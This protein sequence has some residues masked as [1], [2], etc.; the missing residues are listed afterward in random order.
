MLGKIAFA[1]VL[2][3]G[4]HFREKLSFRG[5]EKCKQ[6]TSASLMGTYDLALI[7]IH[8]LR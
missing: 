5:K 3:L 7:N 1:T 2:K 8:I 4:I 6:Q